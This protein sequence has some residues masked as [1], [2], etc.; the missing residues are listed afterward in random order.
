[1]KVYYHGR[2]TKHRLFVQPGVDHPESSEWMEAADHDGKRKPKLF[3]VIFENGIATVD[4]NLGK[5]LITKKSLLENS[6][7]KYH[8]KKGLEEAIEIKERLD[9][10]I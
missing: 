2:S 10:I 7:L 4:D 5:Y 3:D 8:L 9:K 6:D 1:M